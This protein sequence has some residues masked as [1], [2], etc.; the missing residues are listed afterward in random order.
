M[1]GLLNKGGGEVLVGVN[2]DDG[3]VNGVELSIRSK[4]QF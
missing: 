2:P 1:C 3:N 4:M